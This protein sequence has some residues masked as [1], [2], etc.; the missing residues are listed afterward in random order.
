[1]EQLA[2]A[3]EV[4]QISIGMKLLQVIMEAALF[5]AE[6]LPKIPTEA[7]IA[8]GA[9]MGLV[10]AFSAVG[11]AVMAL[12]F[13]GGP[14]LLIV[15]GVAALVAIGIALYM[16][17]DTVKVPAGRAR[18]DHSCH[19]QRVCVRVGAGVEV[20]QS[21]DAQPSRRWRQPVCR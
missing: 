14:I 9:V 7:I 19:R 12:S 4:V 10:G 3:I 20:R 11:L 16:N 21:P 17:W 15:A 6:W 5:L 13:L 18:V 2:G 8:V 1:M